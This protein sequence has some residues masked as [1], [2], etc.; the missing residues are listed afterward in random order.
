MEEYDPE[1]PND[2]DEIQKSTKHPLK[3]DAREIV[4]DQETHVGKKADS[5]IGEKLLR[6]MGWTEGKGLG[7][8]EQGIVTPITVRKIDG[9]ARTTAILELGK[10]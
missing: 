1:V 7:K 4:V 8:D 10:T 6:K 5:K 9:R 3:M 2:Y